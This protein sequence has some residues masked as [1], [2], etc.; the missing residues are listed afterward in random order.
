M[1]YPGRKLPEGS[2][3]AAA[4][5]SDSFHPAAQAAAA[6]E[7]TAG[8]GTVPATWWFPLVE[9][10]VLES[11]RAAELLAIMED[12]ADEA[13]DEKPLPQPP[14]AEQFLFW[15]R[16]RPLPPIPNSGSYRSSSSSSRLEVDGIEYVLFLLLLLAVELRGR[17]LGRAEDSAEE[18]M[19]GIVISSVTELL[20]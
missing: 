6:V 5:A 20:Y 7:M 12:L 9:S 17:L 3:V 11:G 16:L 13:V 2:A 15:N 1:L 18:G 4:R 14:T 19:A 8:E 10:M